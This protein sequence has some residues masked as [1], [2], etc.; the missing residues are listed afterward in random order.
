MSAG[1]NTYG[2]VGANALSDSDFFGLAGNGGVGNSSGIGTNT[3]YKH[4]KEDPKDP[5]YIICKDP[6]GK[7]V[8][9]K[10]RKKKPKDFPDSKKKVLD[11]PKESSPPP[12]TP[13]PNDWG[14]KNDP[15]NPDNWNN[16]S[17][18]LVAPSPSPNIPIL[19]IPAMAW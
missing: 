15:G 17:G 8:R 3:P 7:K 10:V 13:D 14:W 1:N 2:Y 12:F 6:N 4:C 16:H 5:N 11:C 9:K 19:N 18:N